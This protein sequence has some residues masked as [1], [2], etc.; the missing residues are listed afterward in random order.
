[1]R[2]NARECVWVSP[3]LQH[4]KVDGVICDH[5]IKD[6][7]KDVDDLRFVLKPKVVE[8][9]LRWKNDRDKSFAM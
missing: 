7:E 9:V 2:R 4:E 6:M 8:E 1:M 3:S 5:C